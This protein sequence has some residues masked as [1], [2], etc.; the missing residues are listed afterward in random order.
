[1][2]RGIYAAGML[3]AVTAATGTELAGPREPL[4]HEMFQDHAV[5]QRDRPIPIWGSAAA[6][7]RISL[8]IGGHVASTRADGSGHWQALLPAMPAGG[9]YSLNVQDKTSGANQTLTD[10]LVGDVFLCSG[11]SNM[12]L[13]VSSSINAGREISNS[14]NDSI[15]LLSV[16]HA[17]SATAL[18]HFAAP[19]TWAAASP[20]SVRDFS[21]A[22]FYFARDLQKTVHVP[23][24]L[25]HSSW[26]GSRI[27]PWMS[28]AGLRKVGGFDRDLDLMRTYA[29]DPQAANTRWG[30]LWETWWHA[31]AE[32]D[33]SPWAGDSADWRAVPE[34]MRDWK[35]WGVPELLNHDG[36]VWFRRAVTLTAVQATSDATLSIGA[37]DEIDETWVNGRPIANSFGYSTERTYHV[38]AGLLHAGENTLT[39]NVLSTWDAG[40]MYG[41]PDHMALR[42]ADGS[43]VP[44][45]GSW[46]YKFVPE[47]MG[48][49]PRA[50][51][52]SVNGLTTLYNAMI[53]PLGPYAL[54]G[55][56]WYQGES[57]AGDAQQYRALLTGLMRDW[58]RQLG[59]SLPFLIVQLPNFGAPSVAPRESDWA[60]LREAQR[61]AVTDDGNAA[62]AVTID[63][64]DAQNLHPPDKQQV[65]ARLARAARHLIYGD[66]LSP[67]GAVPQRARRKG[68][69]VIVD[70][71][72]IDG[73]L[74]T[75]SAVRP[76]GFELC[77]AERQT[78]RFAD[79]EVHGHSIVLD[80]SGMPAARVRFCWGDAPI[81]N[82][83]DT[84]GLPVGPF[85]IPIT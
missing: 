82:L 63:V 30:S 21:A 11:Q 77:G 48:Y 55:V 7:D 69:Q 4:L 36:M 54:R 10:I 83:Y 18:S 61:L 16:A 68:D 47:R 33:S 67:W 34:P 75:Y 66:P 38:P 6:N 60:N 32:P 80:A 26:G 20:T 74:V 25:I 41:P 3:A 9:P 70:F 64:G 23:I 73:S 59:S 49:P 2:W 42:F 24:G 5:L 78:C 72:A 52:G 79:G 45:G 51:W 17:D 62:L 22:C 65:G 19:V 44:L 14:A 71:D 28:D 58:R 40:G 15:R 43:Q 1:M 81:C 27:E 37:I 84:S 53:A 50:P 12:E 29:A 85:E 31:H 13:P 35:T 57:N 8:S 39:I 46:L 56:L 76:T